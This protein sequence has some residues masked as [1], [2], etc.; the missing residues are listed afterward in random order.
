VTPPSFARVAFSWRRGDRTGAA[1]ALP[2]ETLTARAGPFVATP[3][4]DCTTMPPGAAR[5]ELLL[6]GHWDL[7]D[8]AFASTWFA[9]E[10]ADTSYE[11]PERVYGLAA[12][13][14][15]VIDV[16]VQRDG[17]LDRVVFAVDRE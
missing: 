15:A 10:S 3:S 14:R 16:S 2:T 1:L 6:W 7:D 4:L 9:R 5:Y 13:A 11:M 8:E 12:L 17:A